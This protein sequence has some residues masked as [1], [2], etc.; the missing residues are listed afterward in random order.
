MTLVLAAC[1]GGAASLVPS[2]QRSS[3]TARQL[4]LV[5]TPDWNT[6]Q[7]ELR[8]F[9][10]AVPGSR[11]RPV[12]EAGADRGREERH[13]LGSARDAGGARSDEGGR[14]RAVAR[15]RVLARARPSATR[16]QPTRRG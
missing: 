8:R 15:G 1:G 6:V 4:I 14:R 9:E 13:R 2:R 7:G 12:G 16:R 5:V 3:A 10:R 11:W